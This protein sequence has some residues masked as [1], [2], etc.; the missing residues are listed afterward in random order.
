MSTKVFCWLSKKC[1]FIKYHQLVVIES[2]GIIT[3][4]WQLNRKKPKETNKKKKITIDCANFCVKWRGTVFDCFD[5][6]INHSSWCDECVF[7]SKTFNDCI[8]INAMHCSTIN[9]LQLN[10][11]KCWINVI[12]LLIEIDLGIWF[13]WL[14][15][16]FFLQ[17]CQLEFKWTIVDGSHE[18]TRQRCQ[19]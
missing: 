7:V 19:C 12:L 15:F 1:L 14:V 2:T 4:Y 11:I 10:S 6:F 8:H 5:C 3:Y 9:F 13:V 16:F 17:S 18:I